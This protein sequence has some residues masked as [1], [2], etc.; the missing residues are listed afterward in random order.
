MPGFT[1]TD[2][3]TMP[4]YLRRFYWNQLIEQKKEENSAKEKQMKQQKKNLP[5]MPRKRR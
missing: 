5:K 2:V 4:T 3:Y 1:H